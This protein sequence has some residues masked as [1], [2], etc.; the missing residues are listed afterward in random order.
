MSTVFKTLSGYLRYRGREGHWGFLLHRITGLGVGLFL[1]IHILDTAMV[2]FNPGLYVEAIKL[3]QST[4]FGIGE[5]LLVFCIFYHGLNGLRVAY[6]DLFAPHKWEI[7][8][9][10]NLVRWTLGI[11]LVLW[12]PAAIWMVRGLLIHNFGLFGG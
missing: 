8:T 1:T 6:F 5:I 11:S 3:Y 12:F 10:R 9:Q 7:I 4:L 2:Y